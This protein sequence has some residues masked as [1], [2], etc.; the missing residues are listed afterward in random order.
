MHS[1][2]MVDGY[3]CDLFSSIGIVDFLYVIVFAGMCAI[4]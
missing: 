1:M 2:Y 4:T 3:T